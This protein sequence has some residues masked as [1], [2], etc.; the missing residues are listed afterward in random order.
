MGSATWVLT[1]TTTVIINLDFFF[2]EDIDLVA[3]KKINETE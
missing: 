2:Q 1:A 3:I